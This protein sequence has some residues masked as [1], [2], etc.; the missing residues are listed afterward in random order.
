ML[1]GLG[2]RFG[3]RG[4]FNRCSHLGDARL[5]SQPWVKRVQQ[6]LMHVSWFI[7]DQ[8]SRPS[9]QL[10]CLGE[11]KA[12]RE[13]YSLVLA[14]NRVDCAHNRLALHKSCRSLGKVS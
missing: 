6:S 4:D 13:L 14:A 7:N 3:G 5:Y 12:R 8:P 2:C 1:V 11:F 9:I 10:A